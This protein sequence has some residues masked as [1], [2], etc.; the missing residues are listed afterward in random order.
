MIEPFLRSQMEPVIRR[1]R[2]LLRRRGL[3]VCWGAGALFGFAFLLLYRLT[4]WSSALTLPFL[5]IAVGAATLLTW[6]RTQKWEPDFHQIARQ[7]EQTHPD[8]RALVVTAVE[9]HPDPATGKLGYL[10]ERVIREA[11]IESFKHDWV[12]TVSDRRLWGMQGAQLAALVLL[13]FALGKL[14]VSAP[15]GTASA[16]EARRVTV[17]PGDASIEKGNGLAVLA[18]F[19]GRLP[20]EVTLVVRPESQESRHIQLFKT[21]DDPVFGGSIPEVTSD[22]TYHVEYGDQQTRSTK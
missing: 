3:A 15:G 11:I 4:G 21:L 20:S 7:I 2:R 5:G 18:R 19:A 16:E 17:T 8:L 14:H 10:Q 12:D 22:L 1:Y 6:R 9:Q 13:L